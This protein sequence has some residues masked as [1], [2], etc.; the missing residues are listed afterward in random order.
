MPTEFFGG[1]AS[2]V[3]VQKID[4]AKLVKTHAAMMFLAWGL[5]VPI[6]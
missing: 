6:G 5:M 4:F 1:N 2:D 3:P